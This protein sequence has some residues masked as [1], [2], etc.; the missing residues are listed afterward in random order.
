MAITCQG[1][2]HYFIIRKLQLLSGLGVFGQSVVTIYVLG[3]LLVRISQALIALLM[4][5]LS[6]PLQ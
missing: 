6:G 3:L 4:L 5:S 1:L 2:F